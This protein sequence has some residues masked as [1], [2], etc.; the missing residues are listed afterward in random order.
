VVMWRDTAIPPWTE[1][2]EGDL[3]FYLLHKRGV[4]VGPHARTAQ[5]SPRFNARAP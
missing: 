2:S 1:R 5:P 3:L 4:Y